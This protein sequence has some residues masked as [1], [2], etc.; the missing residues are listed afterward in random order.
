MAT[1]APQLTHPAHC[2]QV[3]LWTPH[4]FGPAT[5]VTRHVRRRVHGHKDDLSQCASMG[6]PPPAAARQIREHTRRDQAWSAFVWSNQGQWQAYVREHIPAVQTARIVALALGMATGRNHLRGR[7]GSVAGRC[8]GDGCT[9]RCCRHR[10]V[11]PE[12][13]DHIARP[14]SGATGQIDSKRI[15]RTIRLYRPYVSPDRWTCPSEL[16]SDSDDL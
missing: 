8:R 4:V 10:R 13:P 14:S 16:R 15:K 6:L 12:W 5:R 2:P 7:N 3:M 11:L 1:G 9:Y